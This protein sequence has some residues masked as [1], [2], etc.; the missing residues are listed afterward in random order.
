M[1]CA[2]LGISAL[3]RRVSPALQ[4]AN[5]KIVLDEPLPPE[6]Y[7]VEPRRVFALSGQAEYVYKVMTA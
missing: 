4:V 2:H 1:G 7:A 6:I 5:L 3:L